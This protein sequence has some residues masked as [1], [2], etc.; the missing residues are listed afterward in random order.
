MLSNRNILASMSLFV[1][2]WY[3]FARYCANSPD[4]LTRQIWLSVNISNLNV[5]LCTLQYLS[6]FGENTNL[7]LFCTAY[8]YLPV[9]K[10]DPVTHARAGVNFE[11]NRHLHKY[12]SE[13][14][15]ILVR[16]KWGQGL[17]LEGSRH[18]FLSGESDRNNCLWDPAY[19][20]AGV[21]VA[22]WF[23]VVRRTLLHVISLQHREE[24]FSLWL[25]KGQ[26]PR[27]VMY[28]EKN[29][30]ISLTLLTIIRANALTHISIAVRFDQKGPE[31]QEGLILINGERVMY[32]IKLY[33][34]RGREL[35]IKPGVLLGCRKADEGK[36]QDENPVIVL[37]EISIFPQM[38]TEKFLR[39]LYES[40]SGI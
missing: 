7:H 20:K 3:G 40:Y 33:N 8:L 23:K 38:K 29:L 39:Q 16:T 21:T 11:L 2:T 28:L 6:I 22:L 25:I 18:I 12:T 15:G 10:C 17:K 9:P 27:V 26:A 35:P 4:E 34:F 24:T 13:H 36:C 32:K 37:D 31:F 30:I 1:K 5:P 14:P 19:C